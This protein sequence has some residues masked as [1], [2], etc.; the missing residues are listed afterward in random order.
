MIT[1]MADFIQIVITT[2]AALFPI[3]NPLG[4][5]PIFLSITDGEKRATRAAQALKGSLYVFLI[6]AGFL[7][8]GTFILSFFGISLPG[9]R[10]AG[11]FVVATVGMNLLRSAHHQTQQPDEKSEAED[12]PD[13]SF[14]PLALPLIAGP[15]AI[16]VVMTRSTENPHLLSMATL[17]AL[18]GI[19]LLS[20]TCWI[21]LREAD[22]VLSVLGVNGAN[23]L[24]KIM[25]FLLLCIGV[26]LIIDGIRPVFGLH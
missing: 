3:C 25:A 8:A 26:Q 15:G 10:I 11:G 6:L 16:A 21:V 24:T 2:Y 4:N 17:A 22:K 14:T 12:K 7:I 5:A 18:T 9:V 20:L 13:I 1:G 23:A 19:L